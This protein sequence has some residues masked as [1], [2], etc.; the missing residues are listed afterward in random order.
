[1]KVTLT[2]KQKTA[3]DNLAVTFSADVPKNNK[4]LVI[5][6]LLNELFGFMSI[7]KKHRTTRFLSNEVTDITLKFGRVTLSTEDIK[8]NGSTAEKLLRAKMKLRNNPKGKKAFAVLFYDLCEYMTRQIKPISFDKLLAEI[9]KEI[10]HE[11]K[12]EKVALN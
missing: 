2:A 3:E 1:M 9:E 4:G 11:A 8:A 5:G 6:T 10:A 12:E 7:A